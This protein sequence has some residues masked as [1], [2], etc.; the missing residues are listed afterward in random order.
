MHRSGKHFLID[1][2]Y[3]SSY[4]KPD[5]P[6]VSLEE[7]A[8]RISVSVLPYIS[9]RPII[10]ECLL[11]VETGKIYLFQNFQFPLR[12]KLCVKCKIKLHSQCPYWCFVQKRSVLFFWRAPQSMNASIFIPCCISIFVVKDYKTS[13]KHESITRSPRY[14][15]DWNTLF[16][17]WWFTGMF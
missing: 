6:S 15:N 8:S 11:S 16:F 1:L 2:H 5:W 4:S 14:H 13:P 10:T 3:I 9:D 12:R 7:M 17:P